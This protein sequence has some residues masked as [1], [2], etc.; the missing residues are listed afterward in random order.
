MDSEK[1]SGII[2]DK[3]LNLSCQYNTVAKEELIWSLEVWT[4]E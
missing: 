2:A 3:Q 4:K 1:N